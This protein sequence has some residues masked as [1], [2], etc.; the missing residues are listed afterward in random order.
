[1]AGRTNSVK[2]TIDGIKF[3]SKIE[4]KVYQEFKLDPLITILEYHPQFVL[5]KPFKRGKAIRGCKYSAD[6]LILENGEQTVVEVKSA[7]SAKLAD[8]GIRKKLF[9]KLYDNFNFKEIIFN[10]KKR[11]ETFYPSNKENSL[12]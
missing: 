8:Y 7:W 5:I 3:D 4:A 12:H 6:F 10:G 2:T 1:M 11:T 9:L